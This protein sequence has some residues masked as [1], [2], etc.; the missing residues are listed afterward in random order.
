MIT[1][2]GRGARHG[3]GFS[4]AVTITHRLW[5]VSCFPGSNRIAGQLTRPAKGTHKMHGI[6]RLALISALATT[7]LATPA[8]AQDT[9]DIALDKITVT[10][11]R[12]VT[13]RKRTGVSATVISG[14]DLGAAQ[15]L[16]IASAFSRLAGL[17]VVQQG[18]FGSPASV[19]IRGADQRYIAVFIDGIRVSDPSGVQ[20]EFDFGRLPTAG[21]DRIEILRGSQ[22]AL[23]GGSAVGGVINFTTARPT[24]D[25]TT[26]QVQT[27]AG[28]FGT[29]SLSYSLTQKTTDLETALTL[30]HLRTD[31][32]S[33]AATGTERDGAEATRASA[34]LRY[35]LTDMLTLG[36]AAF[37][38]KTNAEFDGYID[39]DGDTYGDTFADLPN[40]KSARETGLRAFAELSLG[41]TEHVFDVTRYQIGRNVSDEN[42]VGEFKGNRTTVSWQATSDIIANLSLVYGADT[43]LE[44][45]EYTNLPGGIADTRLSGAFAQALWAVTPQT[46]ISATVRVDHNSTFGNFSTGRIALAFRPDDATT[47]RAAVA[48]GYRAPSID[49]RFGNYPSLFFV[50]NPA[51]TPEES[52]SLELGAEHEFAGGAVVSATV[53]R[54]EVDNLITSTAFFDSLENIDGTSVRQGVELGAEIP[55]AEHFRFGVAYT[56]TDA[57]RPDRTVGEKRIGLVPYH[58]LAAM[59]DSDI[60]DRLSA[61]LSVKHAAGRK[62]DFGNSDMPDYTVVNAQ[63]AYQISDT[64]EVY[65]RIENLFDTDYQTSVGYA[66]AG[67][68]AYVGLRA[69]F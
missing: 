17:S 65:M 68:S 7:A 63:A 37:H 23:W 26:Q 1:L 5:K 9:D 42:G 22:S 67:R 18:A 46:D 34:I 54:L 55:L 35:H 40:V 16:G 61:G 38:Q 19:R 28:S 14:S 39:T 66:S 64:A 49:E 36:G 30:T 13:D 60:T 52:L 53:F 3:S 56:Y 47:L 2:S 59:L 29:A 6:S 32:F 44:K 48:T 31:G 33:A 4:A 10:A 25:G 27:E 58:E 20:T 45:A 11:N 21:I 43:M 15:E 62:D 24:E 50:G 8:L 69:R 51:L 41:N 57:R 12:T